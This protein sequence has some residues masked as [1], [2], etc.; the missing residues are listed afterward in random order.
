MRGGFSLKDFKYNI[1]TKKIRRLVLYQLP[2]LFVYSIP[3]AASF[4]LSSFIWASF[5]ATIA[6]FS[7][8]NLDVALLT[9]S[10]TALSTTSL[11]FA[12]TALQVPHQIPVS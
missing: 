8:K 7:A 10:L 6:S 9:A 4:A 1:Y 2:D 3:T 12:L 5:S 11:I